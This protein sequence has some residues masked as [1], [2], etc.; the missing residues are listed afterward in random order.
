MGG[1]A[2]K[3]LMDAGCRPTADKRPDPL[4]HL[5][6]SVRPR[7]NGMAEAFVRTLK[8]DYVR[9][10]AK[11]DARTSSISC[12]PGSI[13]ITKC[14]R[15]ARSAIDRRASLSTAQPVRPVRF[16]GGN[17]T[18]SGRPLVRR[19]PTRAPTG[20]CP[21]GKLTSDPMMSKPGSESLRSRHAL[22]GREP[23]R[24]GADLRRGCGIMSRARG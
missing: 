4:L 16:L 19:G 21:S 17:N 15:I 20:T 18:R 12:Q 3:W 8:R 23:L 6:N 5:G 22:N 9:I 11:P 1:D 10:S 2:S 7:S 13:T 14:I 24:R